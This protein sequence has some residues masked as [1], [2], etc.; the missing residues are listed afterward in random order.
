MIDRIFIA[1]WRH[2]LIPLLLT[3][4]VIGGALLFAFGIR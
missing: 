2:R 4:A 3:I 1:D